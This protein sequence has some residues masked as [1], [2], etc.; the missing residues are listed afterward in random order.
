MKCVAYQRFSPRPT[1]VCESLEFQEDFLRKYAE[2]AQLEI[3]ESIRE[4]EVSA[5]LVPLRKRDGGRRL[6]ELT[7][8]ATPQYRV[9]I[10]YRIDRLFRSVIDGNTTLAAW[11]R[12]GVACHFAAEGG[13]SINTETATGRF[14]VNILLAKCEYEPD[15]TSERTASAMARHMANGRAMGGTPPYG[16]RRGP[17]RDVGGGVMRPTWED[18][19]AEQAVIAQVKLLAE[20][21]LNSYAI[22]EQL[23]VEGV[24]SRSGNG[25]SHVTIGR[26]IDR[27][28]NRQASAANQA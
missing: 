28:Q 20:A 9:V 24:P 1:D 17:L 18:D 21:G 16:K 26:I 23:E 7:T 27:L 6:W 19:P 3:A 10:A 12:S 2:F 25:W 22:A 8:G 11:R 15:L 4:P 13:Q 5:R 14:I